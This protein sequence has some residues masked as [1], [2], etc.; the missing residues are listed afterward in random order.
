MRAKKSILEFYKLNPIDH[1]IYK[2][3]MLENIINNYDSVK[4]ILHKN[5]IDVIDKDCINM[6]KAEIHFTYRL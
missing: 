3:N 5:L 6:L 1:W 2:A 4:K